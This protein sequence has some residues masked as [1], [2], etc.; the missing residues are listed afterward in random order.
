MDILHQSINSKY[1]I[2]DKGK[3]RREKASVKLT[4]HDKHFQK[5][6]NLI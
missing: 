3:I 2:I 6:K 5:S 1:I 4:S